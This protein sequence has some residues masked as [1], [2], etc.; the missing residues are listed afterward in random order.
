MCKF[1][2][3]FAEPVSENAFA[4]LP[5]AS[6]SIK[7]RFVQ[8]VLKGDGEEMRARLEALHPAVLDEMPLDFEETFIND[9][10]RGAK[11]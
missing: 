7:G 8:I 2:L 6:L 3:A 5:I 11:I 9:V 10:I 1:E 4:G